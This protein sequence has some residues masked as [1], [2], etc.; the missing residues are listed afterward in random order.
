MDEGRGSPSSSQRQPALMGLALHWTSAYLALRVSNLTCIVH[1]FVF[2]IVPACTSAPRLSCPQISRPRAARRGA[3]KSR[4]IRKSIPV[5]TKFCRRHNRLRT[6]EKY[7]RNWSVRFQPDLPDASS[8][9]KTLLRQNI[10][11]FHAQTPE[12]TFRGQ[13][14]V[15]RSELFIDGFLSNLTSCGTSRPR[16]A[17]GIST[18]LPSL[19]SRFIFF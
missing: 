5:H 13:I 18:F 10:L 11:V 9:G 17:A 19:C 4:W 3:G 15:R 7:L 12:G 2:R 8:H 6:L 14:W 1:P 16:A